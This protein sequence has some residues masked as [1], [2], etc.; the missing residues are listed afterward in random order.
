MITRRE[1]IRENI[2]VDY[3]SLRCLLTASLELERPRFRTS[4]RRYASELSYGRY[5]GP[6]FS[7]ARRA[8]VVMLFYPVRDRWCLP[9]TLRPS[10]LPVHAGQVSLP[11]GIVKDGEE[12]CDAALRELNEELGVPLGSVEVLGPLNDIY[13]FGSDHLV[14]PWL[15]MTP[16]QPDWQANVVEVEEL[17]E[18]QM[19]QLLDEITL[20]T[21]DRQFFGLR[22][23]SPYFAIGDHQ[24]WG[25][26]CVMLGELVERLAALKYSVFSEATEK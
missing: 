18:V 15:A 22:F 17:I 8:S 10:S 3:D 1:N 25:A 13:I 19:E 23:R 12:S 26:T 5:E 21:G 4:Y 7:T 16:C 2:T 20:Q 6:S 9:L 11:G 24:V 14:T